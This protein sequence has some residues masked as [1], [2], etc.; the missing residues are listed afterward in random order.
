LFKGALFWLQ[1]AACKNLESW[2]K[3]FWDKSNPGRREKKDRDIMPFIVATMFCLH[4][5]RAVHALGSG[6]YQT[7]GITQAKLKTKERKKEKITQ[8]IVATSLAQLHYC[9]HSD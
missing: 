8:L 5:P 3:H 7:S 1:S 4:H 6:C 2:D 9:T